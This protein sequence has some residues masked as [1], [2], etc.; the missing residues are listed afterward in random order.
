MSSLAKWVAAV[1]VS[2][3]AVWWFAGQVK[4]PLDAARDE[5]EARKARLR[6]QRQTLC[7]DTAEPLVVKRDTKPIKVELHPNCWTGMITYDLAKDEPYNIRM[8]CNPIGVSSPFPPI[9]LVAY[10]D[11]TV[12]ESKERYPIPYPYQIQVKGQNA[13]FITHFVK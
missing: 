7:A 12:H 1:L 9:C 5:V 13:W 11:N 2:A 6:E 8:E 10:S 3:V 4:S